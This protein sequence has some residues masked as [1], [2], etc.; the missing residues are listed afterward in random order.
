MCVSAAKCWTRRIYIVW[1]EMFWMYNITKHIYPTT[2]W[3]QSKKCFE[4]PHREKERE[5]NLTRVSVVRIWRVKTVESNARRGNFTSIHTHTP[6]VVVAY[7]YDA[8]RA[9]NI[10]QAHFDNAADCSLKLLNAHF[11]DPNTISRDEFVRWEYNYT[12]RRRGEQEVYRIHVYIYVYNN[13]I[14]IVI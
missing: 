11:H 14:Y 1:V 3:N 13:N 6:H 7:I 4:F 10:I 9:F 8:R 2:F 12:T 5:I